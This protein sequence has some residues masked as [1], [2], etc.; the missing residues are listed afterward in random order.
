MSQS[1]AA[2]F[3]RS[4]CAETPDFS[5]LS[6]KVAPP[7]DHGISITASLQKSEDTSTDFEKFGCGF[8][9]MLFAQAS[10]DPVCLAAAGRALIGRLPTS[11]TPNF[12]SFR[13]L[14]AP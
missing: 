3:L 7:D 10:K 14:Y 13:A 4:R 8:S 1:G 5:S 11:K 9:T 2:H 12:V 6:L